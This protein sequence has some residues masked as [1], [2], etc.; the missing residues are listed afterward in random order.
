MIIDN[1]GI[2][3]TDISF[4]QGFPPGLPVVDFRKMRSYGFD[5]VIIKAG[6]RNYP[7]PAFYV[8]WEAAKGVLPRSTYWYYSND[9]SA[10]A[11]ASKYWEIIKDDLEGIC[12][13]DLE[14]NNPGNYRGFRYWYDF[15]ETFAILSGLPDARIGIYTAYYYW[16]DE[17]LK[18]NA[19]Q[20]DYF[21]RYP[22]WLADYGRAGSDPMQPDFIRKVVP[23]PWRDV[24]CLIVQT[25]TPV[26]GLAAGVSSLEIDMNFFNGDRARFNSVFRPVSDV[27]ISIRSA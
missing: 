14:D 23:K 27:T 18:A 26:I 21:R 22:L 7:D 5:F 15:L 20:R 25:G 12:W 6:Q 11:Q 13:L 9:Y 17:M 19:S 1:H 4:Y 3:G 8:S 16:F 2:T 24:D 10:I